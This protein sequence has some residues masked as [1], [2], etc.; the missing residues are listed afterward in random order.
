LETA[1]NGLALAGGTGKGPAKKRSK[2]MLE[3]TPKDDDP[4]GKDSV[5]DEKKPAEKP[6]E[7]KK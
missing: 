2:T 5:K 3:P 7:E 6:P 1:A 4:I